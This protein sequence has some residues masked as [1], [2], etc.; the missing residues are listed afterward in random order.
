MTSYS[1][2][3]GSIFFLTIFSYSTIINNSRGRDKEVDKINKMVEEAF[4]ISSKILSIFIVIAL[5][6]ILYHFLNKD[7]TTTLVTSLLSKRSIFI[8]IIASIVI[9]VLLLLPVFK[10]HP[11]ANPQLLKIKPRIFQSFIISMILNSLLICVLLIPIVNKVFDPSNPTE[12]IATISRK[13]KLTYRKYPDKCF[14]YFSQTFHD[15]NNI[16]VTGSEFSE[17]KE[18][19]QI[20]LQIANG[21]LGLKYKTGTIQVIKKESDSSK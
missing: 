16:E 6:S 1:I 12:E 3:S 8:H 7:L 13:E 10:E 4:P 5:L 20:K 18:G 11:N 17:V 21:F 2:V 14:L 19:D 9:D 15:V